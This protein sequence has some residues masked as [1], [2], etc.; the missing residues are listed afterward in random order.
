MRR[1]KPLH[2][3]AFLIDQDRRDRLAEDAAQFANKRRYLV[4]RFDITLEEDKTPRKLRANEL[5]LSAGQLGPRQACNECAILHS[6][7]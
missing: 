3:T 1:P 2:P 6:A 4:R 5:A 7:D